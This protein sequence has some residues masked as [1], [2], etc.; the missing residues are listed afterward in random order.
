MA[1]DLSR[2]EQRV[3]LKAKPE[4]V[5]RALTDRAE[6]ASWW[7]SEVSEEFAEGKTV[8]M[9]HEG[10]MVPVDI[11]EMRP[12]SR[13]VWR[14]HP[15]AREKDV[16]YAKE[17]KTTVSFDLAP[18]HEGTLLTVRETGFDATKLARRPRAFTD[19]VN[20]WLG[21]AAALQKFLG[22]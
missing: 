10:E 11:V 6:F 15:G 8:K 9:V 19:N 4:R 18:F 16:D 2:I 12:P 13:L 21:Q 14:W 1:E 5:W 3:Y 7:G 22:E 17:P 20:G